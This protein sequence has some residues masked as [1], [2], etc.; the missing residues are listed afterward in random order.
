MANKII[1]SSSAQ[2]E[3]RESA[4]WYKEQSPGLD[5]QF[6]E[7]IYNSLNLIAK[8]PEIYKLIK[9]GLREFIVEKFPF[10]IIY[11]YDGEMINVVHIFHTSRNPKLKY[12]KS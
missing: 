12:R 8:D 9:F 11:E 10:V 2:K 4:G 5:K 7:F 6:S 3:F 1:L